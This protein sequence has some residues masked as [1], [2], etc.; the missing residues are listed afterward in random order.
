MNR[1]NGYLIFFTIIHLTC[2]NHDLPAQSNFKVITYATEDGG[3]IEAS[4]FS[5]STETAI[6]Y[7]H[8]AVFNKESWYFLAKRF[9]KIGLTSLPIDF[10]GYGNSTGPDKNKKYYDILGAIEYLK[11]TGYSKLYLIGGSMGGHAVLEALSKIDEP[12]LSKVVLLA[13][14]GGPP[15]MST[16]IDKLVVL[17]E[18]EGLFDRVKTVFDCSSMPKT[19]KIY[20]G[21]AHAQ[22][23]FK[24][25]YAEELIGIIINFLSK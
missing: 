20:E 18:N 13:P 6:I 19:L 25:Q 2:M 16:S 8:G 3:N 17:T 4:L 15:I 14:A 21:S 9:Q 1:L 7:A 10:R 24:E 11:N 23:M 12:T 5:A 22:H